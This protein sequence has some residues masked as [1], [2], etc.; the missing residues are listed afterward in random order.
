M[1]LSKR[2]KNLLKKMSE[3]SE[4]QLQTLLLRSPSKLVSRMIVGCFTIDEIRVTL[5]DLVTRVH[6]PETDPGL[7]VRLVEDISNIVKGL[8]KARKRLDIVPEKA[9]ILIGSEP[10][11]KNW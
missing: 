10:P 7:R 11:E 1:S 2:S 9:W 6:D 4:N 3:L 8:R 5:E